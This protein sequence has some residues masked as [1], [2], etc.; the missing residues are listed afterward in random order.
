MGEEAFEDMCQ[1]VDV[2][3]EIYEKDDPEGYKKAKDSLN[4]DIDRYLR[5]MKEKEKKK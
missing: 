2:L 3:S 4:Q 5:L 1:K